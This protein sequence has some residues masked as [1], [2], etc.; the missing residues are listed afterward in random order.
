MPIPSIEQLKQKSDGL[1]KKLA[2][3]G[4]GI[5]VGEKR[6]LRKQLKRAQRKGRRL[7]IEVERQKKA[8]AKPAEAAEE[9]AAE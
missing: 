6:K 5:E 4:D 2:D 9:A 3:K 8:A 1:A 7:H